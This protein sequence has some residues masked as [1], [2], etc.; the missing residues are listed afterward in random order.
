MVV[1]IVPVNIK[2]D[3]SEFLKSLNGLNY[4]D[5]HRILTQSVRA[6]GEHVPPLVNAY[7]NLSSTMKSF[8]TSLNDHFGEVEETGIL[9]TIADIY[10]TK[11]ERHV[12]T[13]KK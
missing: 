3:V 4:K 5:G 6:L 10:E 7:M 1:P 2:T 9:V 11:M 12:A 13:Y 8:G